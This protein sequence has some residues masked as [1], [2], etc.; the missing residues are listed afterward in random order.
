MYSFTHSENIYAELG[1]A[2]KGDSYKNL[3][4]TQTTL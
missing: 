3:L 1:F 2:P 4:L